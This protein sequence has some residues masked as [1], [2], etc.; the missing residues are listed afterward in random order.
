MKITTSAGIWEFAIAV[1]HDTVNEKGSGVNKEDRRIHGG[2]RVE[3]MID[4]PQF[5]IEAEVGEIIDVSK[6]AI[7]VAAKN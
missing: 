2:F 7:E 5:T 3:L 1:S 4:A 6:H